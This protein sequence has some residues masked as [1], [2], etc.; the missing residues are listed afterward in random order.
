[1]KALWPLKTHGI[2]HPCKSTIPFF[3]HAVMHKC[4]IL[5]MAIGYNMK[6][7]TPPSLPAILLVVITVKI[8]C[9]KDRYGGENHLVFELLCYGSW[10]ETDI[11]IKRCNTYC[12]YSAAEHSSHLWYDTVQ[13]GIRTPM[14]LM[15]LLPPSSGSW[16]TLK[17]ERASSKNAGTYTPNYIASDL[18]SEFSS[19]PNK[20]DVKS[21]FCLHRDGIKGKQR[22]SS[23]P[24]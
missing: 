17:H 19:L 21:C 6:Q 8:I 24:S 9:G 3:V 22:Y 14:Y 7:K 13:I 12:S 1:M 5:K 18:R 4:K 16:P 15:S 23:A 10:K 2:P 11:T 20:K